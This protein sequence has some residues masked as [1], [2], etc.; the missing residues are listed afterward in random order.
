MNTSPF[1]ETDTEFN[2]CKLLCSSEGT[3]AFTTEIK[4]HVDKL[5][6]PFDVIAAI[7]FDN[8]IESLKATQKA[9][10]HSPSQCE[11]MDKIVVHKRIFNKEKIGGL[12]K[13]I[14]QL[15]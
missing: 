3:L 12:S 5:Q 2:F 11:L 14:P 10:E 6:A 4:L 15:Y 13:V 1:V 8:V 9:M 7:H